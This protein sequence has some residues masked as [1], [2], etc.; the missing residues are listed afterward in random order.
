VLFVLGKQHFTPLKNLQALPPRRPIV[1]KNIGRAEYDDRL[2]S[3][4]SL[5]R[6][7]PFWGRFRSWISLILDGNNKFFCLYTPPV[8]LFIRQGL[9]KQWKLSL[10]APL[11]KIF[12][13][14][15]EA[16]QLKYAHQ[17]WWR[18]TYSANGYEFFEPPKPLS[19]SEPMI[20]CSED[21]GISNIS[22]YNRATHQDWNRKLTE[23]EVR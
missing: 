3:R 23:Q 13:R 11:S 18:G 14:T 19:L 12:H 6:L 5:S 2:M 17:Y 9:W 1:S 20:Y 8:S 21:A 15:F 7:A 10:R 4:L 22:H 16:I